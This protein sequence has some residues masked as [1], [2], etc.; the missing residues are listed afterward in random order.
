MTGFYLNNGTWKIDDYEILVADEK[1]TGFF[2][3]TYNRT[4]KT[5]IWSEYEFIESSIFPSNDKYKIIIS[6]KNKS[7]DFEKITLDGIL[8]NT[9]DEI[10]KAKSGWLVGI[11]ENG[12]ILT[13]KEK[14]PLYGGVINW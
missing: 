2:Y 1:G 10:K 7:G 14:T 13:T 8:K 12:N 3:V 6:L 9:I 4:E 11:E 5:P